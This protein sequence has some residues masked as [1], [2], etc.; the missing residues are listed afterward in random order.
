M[1]IVEIAAE[2][3]R[4]P[5]D[6]SQRVKALR[7]RLGLSQQQFADLFTVSSATVKLWEQG[8]LHPSQ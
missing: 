1:H 7:H 4:P 8:R 5:P 3:F 2:N 6:F